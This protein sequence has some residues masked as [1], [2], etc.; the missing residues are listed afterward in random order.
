[1]TDGSK[2]EGVGGGGVIEPKSKKDRGARNTGTMDLFGN[3]A[4]SLKAIVSS[5]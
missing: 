5:S 4:G 1:M 2:Q 3:T